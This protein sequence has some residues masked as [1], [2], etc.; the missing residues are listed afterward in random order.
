VP[1]KAE[2]GGHYGAALFASDAPVQDTIAT[3]ARLGT[4]VLVEV[5]GE[6]RVAGE[7]SSYAI[8]Y[9]D[10]SG[11]LTVP[12]VFEAFPLSFETAFKNSGNTHLSPTGRIE[13]VDENGE[14]LRG[15][16][17][18]T[19][20]NQAGAF[21]RED[22][23]DYLPINDTA[24]DV[25]PGTTRKFKSPWEGFAYQVLNENGTKTVNFRSPEEYYAN[26]AEAEKKFLQF[27]ESVK[28]R[29][30][31]KKFTANFY[32]SYAGKD[33]QVREFRESKPFEVRYVERY[34]G[35][36]YFVFAALT[37]I[38]VLILGYILYWAPRSRERMRREIMREMA[39]GKDS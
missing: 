39:R 13:I 17:K 34:I 16:G 36:N 2:P 14:K 38:V 21:I 30:V 4:L 24:G 1:P 10:T 8:G 29:T 3:V 25:L 11:K 26:K 23:V 9:S 19:V 5:S 27:W 35:Y 6:L 28:T 22:M 18:E 15:I 12:D 33:Q 31:T 32:V 7:P 37:L 20:M